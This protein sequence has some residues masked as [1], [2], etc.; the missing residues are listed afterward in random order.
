MNSRYHVCVRLAALISILTT[1]AE[2]QEASSLRT[3]GGITPLMHAATYLVILSSTDC[4]TCTEF[5]ISEVGRLMEERS[6]KGRWGFVIA[7]EDDNDRAFA[8]WLNARYNLP[9]PVSSAGRKILEGLLGSEPLRTPCIVLR[10]R[11]GTFGPP[12]AISPGG[13]GAAA[14]FF[15]SLYTAGPGGSPP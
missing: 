4:P 2:S 1:V 12:W 8:E 14:A 6:W 10:D 3:D 15:D 7:S 9:A 5:L 11:Y 13:L